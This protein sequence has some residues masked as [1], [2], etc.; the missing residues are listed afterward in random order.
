[1]VA[2]GLAAVAGI[3]VL[4]PITPNV[5]TLPQLVSRDTTGHGG[6]VLT[7]LPDPDR[8]GEAV[9]ATENSRFWSDPGIDPVG[10]LRV[11]LD[12]LRG[13]NTGGA[14]LEQQLAKLVYGSSWPGPLSTVEQVELGLKIAHRYPK[15][16]ILRL[17]LTE[18]YYGHGYY[19]VSA[20]SRG[21]FGVTPAGLTW[22][23]AA[24]L[25][26]LVQAPSAY[27]PLAHYQLARE[28]ELEVLDRLVATGTLTSREAVLAD[29]APLGLR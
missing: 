2:T 22:G 11:G 25:A 10:V 20:A 12:G 24:M 29:R 19:G 13:E 14:S 21:Y 4:W 26:G 1:M 23:Q 28:R 8:V 17:Y 5:D 3:A 7:G 15:P 16:L 18:A 6:A 9:I 27:D